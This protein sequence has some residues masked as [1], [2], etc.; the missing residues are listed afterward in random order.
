MKL[1]LDGFP[2]MTLMS[3]LISAL[4]GYNGTIFAYGQTGSGKTFTITGGVEK[5]S[6]RGIIPRTLSYLFNYF[7]EVRIF[8]CC[9]VHF[10]VFFFLLTCA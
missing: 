3:F 6:D 1:I 9:A 8:M 5:Y 2:H 7:Q 4:E 10:R